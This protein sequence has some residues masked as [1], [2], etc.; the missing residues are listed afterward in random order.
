MGEDLTT[1]ISLVG[2][3]GVAS[4]PVFA[5][6]W[7]LERTERKTGQAEAKAMID[8]VFAV[9]T[10]TANATVAITEAV[11]ELSETTKESTI[12]LARLVRSLGPRAGAKDRV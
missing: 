1:L 7:W 11:Q 6:L 4:G 3:L 8:R 10:A 5:F 12:S 2:G 9:T